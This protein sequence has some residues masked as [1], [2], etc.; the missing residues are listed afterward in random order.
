M[1]WYETDNKFHCLIVFFLARPVTGMEI[2]NHVLMQ[3]ITQFLFGRDYMLLV[4]S[5]F[6]VYLITMA[7]TQVN[8]AKWKVDRE[9]WNGTYMKYI[10]HCHFQGTILAFVSS[11]WGKQYKKCLDLNLKYPQDYQV[12]GLVLHFDSKKN[13]RIQG[14]G[15]YTVFILRWGVGDTYSFEA[16][17]KSSTQLLDFAFFGIPDDGQVQKP[18]NPTWSILNTNH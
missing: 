13:K 18:T 5:C 12:F 11:D 4:T 8:E 10:C 15:N 14:F 2:F 6:L 16:V 7:S 1:L 17:R 9:W 3:L